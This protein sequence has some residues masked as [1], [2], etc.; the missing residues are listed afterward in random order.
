LRSIGFHASKGVIRFVVLEGDRKSPTYVKHERRP[1]ELIE[2]SPQFIQKARNLFTAVIQ[3]YQPDRLGYVLSMNAKSQ[4]QL[5]GLLLPFG[6]LNWCAL[7]AGKP[8]REFIA[9]NFSK[10]FFAKDALTFSDWKS[11]SD[12]LLG[13]HPPNWTDQERQAGLAAL[14]AM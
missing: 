13:S 8:C 2:D 4:A 10:R 14:G 12:D 3:T 11:A 1:L 5:A 6:A 9:A 7:E